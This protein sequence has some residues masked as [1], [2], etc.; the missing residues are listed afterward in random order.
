[1]SQATSSSPEVRLVSVG[2]GELFSFAEIWR[3]YADAFGA[4]SRREEHELLSLLSDPSLRIFAIES[5]GRLVGFI[6]TWSIGPHLFIEHFAVSEAERGRGIGRAAL[7]ALLAS[8]PGALVVLE[9]DRSAAVSRAQKF[10]E[11]L[12]FLRNEWPYIQP[13]Y[14][15]SKS[16]LPM[17]IMSYPRLLEEADAS[18]LIHEIHARIY[19]LS[20][21]APRIEFKRWLDDW[22]ADST[23]WAGED[24]DR[25]LF[26]HYSEL[27][28]RVRGSAWKRAFVPLCGHSGAVRFLHAQGL[29]VTALDYVPEA[30]ARLAESLRDLGVQSVATR[31]P[32]VF[33]GKRLDLVLADIFAY[34]SGEQFDLVYDRAALVAVAPER[35]KAYA[36]KITE[37]LA[38]EGT[39][40]LDA[41]EMSPPELSEAPYPISREEVAELFPGFRLEPIATTRVH[42]IP[43][44]L[45]ARGAL[46]L[47]K[48]FSALTRR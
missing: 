42:E 11:R 14:S 18:T 26:K 4:D 16:C 39:I 36:A 34:E 47:T 32:V 25:A 38:P 8:N 13:P 17:W 9:V 48:T 15:P 12:G 3:I 40:L 27:S 44:N 2:P 19:G 24:A 30:L 33:C 28:G 20:P 22:R 41:R 29:E 37:L 35:R 1:M 43:P 23:P 21:S 31:G 10:Y 5:G 46:S 6:E 7:K 45:A